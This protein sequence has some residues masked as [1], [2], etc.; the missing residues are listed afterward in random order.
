MKGYAMLS[1]NKV[2]WIEKPVPTIGPMDALVKPLAV[3]PCTSDV[4]TVWESS[5]ERSNLILGHEA[6]GEVVEVGSL[7][8]DFKPGDK[9][10]VSA[11]T[12][13]WEKVESQMGY[14]QHSG[15][16]LRGVQFSNFRDGVFA[17]FFVVI[18]ADGNMAL[19]PEGVGIEEGVMV[20][21][22]VPTGFHGADLAEVSH[23]ETVA[24]IGIGPVGLMAVAGANLRGGARIFAVG[25][26]EICQQ[27]AKF[28]GA[29]DVI[30]YKDGDIVEQIMNATGG[31]K[32]DKVIIAGGDLASF[33]Q[34]MKIVRPAGV[35]SNVN[36]LSTGEYIK[37]NRLDWGL[38]MAHIKIV[39]GLMP[40]GR[41]NMERLSNLLKYKKLDVAPLLTH[42]LKGFDQFEKGLA[43]MKD[44]PRDLIKPVIT[45]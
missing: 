23:G 16:L 6:V 26:R 13:W 1:L 41:L 22:M 2:G 7:V 9:V 19:L 21:D 18:Q 3:S 10:I 20:T 32:V 40:G 14:H 15:G 34:A 11:I 5:V 17:E 45:I 24:V 42:R 25:S 29:T 4:H 44:K 33:E 31:K 12:P 37:L 36:Y 43:L 8:Q 30:N 27:A 38:G 35:V 28:Y 39:G